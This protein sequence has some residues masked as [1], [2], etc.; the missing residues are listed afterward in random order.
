MFAWAGVGRWG[1]GAFVSVHVCVHVDVCVCVQ[2]LTSITEDILGHEGSF[3]S[4]LDQVA[5][6]KES[7]ENQGES[8]QLS[9]TPGG[10]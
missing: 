3:R 1:G 9:C 10:V 4:P 8:L 7:F 2:I 6:I 5:F